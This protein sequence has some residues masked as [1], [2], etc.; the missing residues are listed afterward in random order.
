MPLELV[1][2]VKVELDLAGTPMW[3]QVW[4]ARVGRINLYLLDADVAGNDEPARQVTDRLYGG[5]N[6]H[7]L[8]QE[9][10]LR[11]GGGRAPA[12]LAAPPPLLHMNEGHAGVCTLQ[13]IPCYLREGPTV[14]R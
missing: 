14:P 3:A 4:Y 8:R 12:R 1:D 7:R 5:D 9:I 13:R 2:G 11:M 10:L 6:E